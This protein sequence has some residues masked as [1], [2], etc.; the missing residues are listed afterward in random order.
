MP[1]RFGIAVDGQ[2]YQGVSAEMT[3]GE[4]RCHAFCR[5]MIGAVVHNARKVAEWLRRRV[6]K[7]GIE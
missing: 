2:A 7:F 6:L 5:K 4:R 3:R 1:C